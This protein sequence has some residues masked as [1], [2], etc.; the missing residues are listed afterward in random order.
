MINDVQSWPVARIAQPIEPIA[1]SVPCGEVLKRLLDEPDRP[2]L[3]V[4]AGDRVLGLA[5]RSRLLQIFANPLHRATCERRPIRLV[6]DAEPMLVQAEWDVDAVSERIATDHR[7]A[8]HEGFIIVRGDAY[9]GL[10]SAQDLLDLAVAKA[11]QSVRDI[12]RARRDAI[13]ASAAKS[14]FLASMSHELRTPLNAILGFS[15]M[16]ELDIGGALPPRQREYVSHIRASGTLLLD[17]VNDILDLARVEA[18]QSDLREERVSLST[19]LEKCLRLSGPRIQAKG[20]HI[21]VECARRGIDILADTRR[22]EQI[23]LNLFTNAVKYT[24]D[25]GS[26][27]VRINLDDIGRP[28]FQVL[29]NGIGIAQEHLKRI[30]EPFARVE[31]AYVRETEGSGVGLALA[32][33]LIDLHGGTLD[34]TSTLGVG[35]VVEVRFPAARLIA[36]AP[37]Q[38]A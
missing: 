11:R 18:G 23:M 5:A 3:P 30:L 16:L 12:D 31:S 38:S 22:I 14:E 25:D 1:D 29:D 13:T 8:L 9:V 37:A 32:K 36:D 7:K 27:R 6:M 4:I 2:G 24:P 34:I 28:G 21:I 33:Q 17:L 35:T 19:A 10:G 20:H 26:I 15:Q